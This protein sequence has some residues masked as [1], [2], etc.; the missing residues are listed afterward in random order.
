MN[1]QSRVI[2]F[3]ILGAAIGAAAGYL[4][5]TA[6]GR[7]VLERMEPTVDELRQE[8]DRFR[9]TVQKLGEMAN[10]GMRAVGEFQAARQQSPYS[11]HRPTH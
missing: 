6:R 9:G 4:F 8:F 5:F 2:G 7:A 1:E 11:Q 10:E 3:A